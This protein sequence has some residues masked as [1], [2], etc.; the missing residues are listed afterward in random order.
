MVMKW[1]K[2]KG[3][4]QGYECKSTIELMFSGPI[5]EPSPYWSANFVSGGHLEY[6]PFKAGELEQ[7][8][9]WC[10]N[11]IHNYE[12]QYEGRGNLAG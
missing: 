8:H 2:F 1:N 10:V 7:A 9:G 12:R 5:S 4:I 6:K 11:K 3:T